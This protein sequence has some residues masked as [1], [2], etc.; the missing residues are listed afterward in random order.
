MLETLFNK[1]ERFLIRKNKRLVLKKKEL[2]DSFTSSD[3]ESNFNRDSIDFMTSQEKW[4]LS[5]AF[6]GKLKDE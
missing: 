4:L 2:K 6:T 3:N 5:E 1:K